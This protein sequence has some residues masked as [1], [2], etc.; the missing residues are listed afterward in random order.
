M[1]KTSVLKVARIHL[2]HKRE[3]VIKVVHILLNYHKLNMECFWHRLGDDV[4]LH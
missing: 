4:K 3:M 1:V 2:Q